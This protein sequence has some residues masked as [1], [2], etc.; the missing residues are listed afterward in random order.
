VTFLKLFTNAMIRN[1]KIQNILDIIEIQ[2]L[3]N[4]INV[5]INIYIDMFPMIFQSLMG[6]RKSRCD[7]PNGTTQRCF[8]RL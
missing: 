7:V 2:N 4:I 8:C 5:L 1:I 6:P 3:W